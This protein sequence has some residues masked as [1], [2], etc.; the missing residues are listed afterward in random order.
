MGEPT[1]KKN[2]REM[3]EFFGMYRTPLSGGNSRHTRA[4]GM[5]KPEHESEFRDVDGDIGDQLFLEHKRGSSAIHSR[6]RRYVPLAREE[7]KTLV[8]C[9]KGPSLRGFMISVHSS[10]LEKLVRVL[11]RTG[12]IK[13]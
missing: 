2:E 11:V 3:A 8:L 9:S 10:E 12:R 13:V 4:D 5:P 6:W 7:D 1:W